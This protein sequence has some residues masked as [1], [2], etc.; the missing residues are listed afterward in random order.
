MEEVR[1]MRD[2]RAARFNCDIDAI[3]EDLKGRLRTAANSAASRRPLY[4]VAPVRKTINF[5]RATSLGGRGPAR[6]TRQT[7]LTAQPKPPIR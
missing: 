4:P 5:R 7:R 1:K 2:E 3:F 6:I